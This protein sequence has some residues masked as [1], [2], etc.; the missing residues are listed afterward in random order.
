MFEVLRK[1]DM[2]LLYGLKRLCSSHMSNLIDR[3]NVFH[4]LT[5]SRLF[6]L[7]KA[8]DQ[9]IQFIAA[10]IDEVELSFLDVIP[11]CDWLCYLIPRF[12]DGEE[13]GA[14]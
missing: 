5:L 7:L 1:A 2:Y 3:D 13:A 8:E 11:R 4:V 12:T 10:N 6:S 14:G 9:C